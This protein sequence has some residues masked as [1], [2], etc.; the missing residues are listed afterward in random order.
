L[1]I[2]AAHWGAASQLATSRTR[3]PSNGA[4]MTSS[5]FDPLHAVSPAG[6]RC[7]QGVARQAGFLRGPT[8][9]RRGEALREGCW[10]AVGTSLRNNRDL[11]HGTGFERRRSC[12]YEKDR[13]VRMA[14]WVI[15]AITVCL[16][17]AW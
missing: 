14:S 9:L 8:A 11:R 6:Y 4:V 12:V 7:C 3:T 1:A 2:G 15:L 13:E 10:K 17:A 5:P 16:A